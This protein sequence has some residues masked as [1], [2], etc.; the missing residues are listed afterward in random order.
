MTFENNIRANWAVYFMIAAGLFLLGVFLLSSLFT[1]RV[2]HD[3]FRYGVYLTFGAGFGSLFS[4]S[5]WELFVILAV[6][7]LP[8][9]ALSAV[10]IR[11]IYLPS[12]TEFHFNHAAVFWIFL[13][14]LAV[15]ALSV[16]L[17][18]RMMARKTPVSLIAA[19]DNANLVV[20]PR[21]SDERFFGPFPVRYELVSIKRFR[22]H[23]A[24][25]LA[26]A[27]VFCAVFIMG[28]YLSSIYET[29]LSYPKPQFTVDIS[30][31]GF[32]YDE[33]MSRELYDLPGVTAVALNDNSVS[34][35][36]LE[37]NMVVPS[38]NML[39]FRNLIVYDG[40]YFDTENERWRVSSNVEY[41]ATSEEQSSLLLHYDYTGDISC[42]SDPTC[43]VIGDSLNNITTYRF[44]VGDKI[45]LA[46]KTGQIRA[47]DRYMSGR[48]L[49]K[50][51]IAFFRYEYLEFT[52]GAVLHDNPTTDTPV[53]LHPDS[54]TEL[55]G[56]TPGATSFDLYTDPSATPEETEELFR[57]V[58]EWG[59]QYGD[60]K[61]T[62]HDTSMNT[63][64]ARD[65]H[66]GELIVCLSIL[67]LLISPL[68]W[69][70]SQSL[71]YARREPELRILSAMGAV[72]REIRSVFLLDGGALAALSLAVSL[73]L[74]YGGSYLV[75]LV[76]NLAIPYLSGASV[77]FTFLM[78]WYAI[79]TS[80]AVSVACGFFSAY[81]SYRSHLRRRAVD[82]ALG[83]EFSGE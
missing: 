65:R 42:L 28:L 67:I 75:F 81:R 39:P 70:F 45:Y 24:R 31:S 5:F 10:L 35:R 2:N 25:L 53:Y 57:Q 69:F 34:A 6:T 13:F 22:R 59:R 15:T 19:G 44:E 56:L 38:D 68:V 17:P 74:S 8:A 12:G 27:V 82:G 21:V 73:L 7:C 37:S 40:P 36:R 77:R 48:A 64:V 32:E 50:Q 16:W 33:I 83:S 43:V 58:R 47:A 46:K 11:L 1:I 61:V 23:I 66:Y 51:Q 52:V 30:Q 71:Y 78:P 63:A 76:F 54:Y 62:N 18:M 3:K 60:V 20:S 41:I 4:A 79:L 55:T 9:S 49:T 80:V 29:S 26:T 72:L 14:T